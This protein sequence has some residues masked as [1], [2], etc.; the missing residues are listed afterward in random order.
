[1]EDGHRYERRIHQV[2][3]ATI[4]DQQAMSL[5]YVLGNLI[6]ELVLHSFL[7]VGHFSDYIV[8]VSNYA[9]R[10]L[11]LRQKIHIN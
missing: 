2:S 4:A 5:L 11:E 1:M 6:T 7:L 10:K 8:S 3:G 9:D